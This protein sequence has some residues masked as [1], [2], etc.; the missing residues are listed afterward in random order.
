MTISPQVTQ[1]ETAPP[2]CT[3]SS[4]ALHRQTRPKQGSVNPS[5][6][7]WKR[8]PTSMTAFVLHWIQDMQLSL[9]GSGHRD[10]PTHVPWRGGSG[11]N[12]T[13][14]SSTPSKSCKAGSQPAA[15]RSA[16]PG[17]HASAS[18]QQQ[19]IA[20]PSMVSIRYLTTYREP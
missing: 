1:S 6:C 4:S 7:S 15:Q 5:E 19:L 17:S 14:L 9:H 12:K 10:H 2:A 16:S 13:Q 18:A 3:A 20:C 11:S 8:V